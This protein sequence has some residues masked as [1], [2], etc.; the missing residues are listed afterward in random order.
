[1][2]RF[3]ENTAILEIG[4]ARLVYRRDRHAPNTQ[5]DDTLND[6]EII[7]GQ[8]DAD[9]NNLAHGEP[10]VEQQAAGAGANENANNVDVGDNGELHNV[11][12]NENAVVD[13]QA[14]GAA[15]DENDDG[16][17]S[18]ISVQSD[19]DGNLTK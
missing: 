11:V 2:L 18:I 6:G 15:S 17:D 16:H 8:Q 7:N 5:N 4:N 14:I 9:L 12:Q 19:S 10:I 1:M 13:E 3:T